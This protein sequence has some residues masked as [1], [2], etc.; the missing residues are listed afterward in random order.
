MTNNEIM[1]AYKVAHKIDF[2]TP[3]LTAG[4]WYNKG[5]KIKK[6]EKCRHR[7]SLWGKGKTKTDAEGNKIES[8]VFYENFVL[9]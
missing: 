2:D 1:N 8:K 5:Y 3:L 4:T 9:V 6:G 7:V